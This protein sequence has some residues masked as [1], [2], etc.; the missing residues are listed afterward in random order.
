[1]SGEGRTRR[2]LMPTL[3]QSLLRHAWPGNTRELRNLAQALSSLQDPYGHSSLPDETRQ[4]LAVVLP[5]EPSSKPGK[6][7][8]LPPS[9]TDLEAMV[10]RR[11]SQRQTAEN[12]G[13]HRRTLIRLLN[14]FRIPHPWG[15][16]GP[17]EESTS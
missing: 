5:A 11:I 10:A 4:R 14:R 6:L 7:P 16:E 12:L 1:L 3:A 17:A 9:R 15:N 8:R 2:Q 13:L